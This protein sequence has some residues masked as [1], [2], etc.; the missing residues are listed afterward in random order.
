MKKQWSTLRVFSLHPQIG[1]WFRFNFTKKKIQKM[2]TV[3]HQM[4]FDFV[5]LIARGL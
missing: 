1:P 3:H 4:S 5:N 2:F